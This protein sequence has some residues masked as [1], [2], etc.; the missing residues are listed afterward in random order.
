MR[1]CL[2]CTAPQAMICSQVYNCYS[3]SYTEHGATFDF[4]IFFVSIV[5]QQ[6]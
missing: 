1:R 6:H 3:E 4:V 2:L 5:S